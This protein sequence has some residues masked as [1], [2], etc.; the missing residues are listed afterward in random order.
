MK[1]S[2]NL[3]KTGRLLKLVIFSGMSFKPELNNYTI[4]LV[5]CLLVKV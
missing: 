5:L 4:R 2:D 3:E 1:S